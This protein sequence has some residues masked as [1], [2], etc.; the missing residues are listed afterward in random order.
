MV[1]ES[2]ENVLLIQTDALSFKEFEI[3]EFEIAR[4]DCIHQNNIDCDVCIAICYVQ[5]A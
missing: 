4:V 3:F 1:G 2:N 5:T